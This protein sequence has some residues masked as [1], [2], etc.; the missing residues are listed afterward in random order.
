MASPEMVSKLGLVTTKHPHPYALHWLDDGSSVKVTK[1]ARIGLVMGSYV[2]EELC[3]V[4]PMDA[5]HILLGRP[6][7][8]DRDVL[9]RGRSNEYEL[10]DKGKR[11]VLKPMSPQVV[12][13]LGSKPKAKA[14][15]TM[16]VRERDV[17]RTIDHGEQEHNL[18]DDLLEE[19]GDV[20]P[21]DLPAGLPPI[22]GIEHQIDLVPG[23]TLPNKAAYRCNP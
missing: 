9:H 20:F 15:A 18:I 4:I 21:N 10:K 22:R 7:Q 17:E 5:C 12:R 14:Y 16:L 19:F 3:D 2:D 13:A 11:I 8:Y 6:W 1:Q 23:S